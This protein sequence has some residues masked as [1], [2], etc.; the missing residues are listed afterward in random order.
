MSELLRIYSFRL[1]CRRHEILCCS[2]NGLCNS[3]TRNDIYHGIQ[4][5]CIITIDQDACVKGSFD[6]YDHANK[7]AYFSDV[8]SQNIYMYMI[9]NQS[10]RSRTLF[11]W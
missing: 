9:A 11:I 7:S 5:E 6:T 4:H 1:T 2:C 3:L 8:E 10:E